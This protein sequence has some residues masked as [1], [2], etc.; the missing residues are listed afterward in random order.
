MKREKGRREKGRG[1][2]EAQRRGDRETGEGEEWKAKRLVGE[3]GHNTLTAN[4]M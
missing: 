2:E 1:G 4:V 3:T